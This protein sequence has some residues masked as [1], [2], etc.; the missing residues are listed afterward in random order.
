MRVGRGA[1]LTSILTVDEDI[2][3]LDTYQVAS[4]AEPAADEALRKGNQDI[5]N[6][7]VDDE[8][9][10]AITK[11]VDT[12]LPEKLLTARGDLLTRDVDHPKKLA[13]GTA[14]HYLKQG[15]NEPEWAAAPTALAALTGTYT[16]DSTVNRAIP[17]GLG[18]TPKVVLITTDKAAAVMFRIYD[19]VAKIFCVGSAVDDNL[20]VTAMTSTN[21]YVGNATDYMSSANHD[22][23]ETYY[24]VAIG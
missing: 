1:L 20:A 12:Y 5:T 7:E 6:A 16:G 4:L 17:H 11:L 8:A 13:K 3:F 14:G 15:A 19:N 24:W 21:F 10:I 2:D 9:E 18:V 22:A 23:P